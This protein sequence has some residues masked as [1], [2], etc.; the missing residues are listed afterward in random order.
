MLQYLAVNVHGFFKRLSSF[1]G[2]S[3]ATTKAQ[4]KTL[5]TSKVFSFFGMFEKFSAQIS[6][7]AI[8]TLALRNPLDKLDQ[9]EL[10]FKQV[11]SIMIFTMVGF[12]YFCRKFINLRYS[13]RPQKFEKSSKFY[14]M[15]H[16]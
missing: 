3:R 12:V 7:C 5:S 8:K 10:L 16:N 14:L 4:K 9:F 13:R 15:L 2:G 1:W 11:K 6:L